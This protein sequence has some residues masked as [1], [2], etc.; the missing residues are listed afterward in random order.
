MFDFSCALG[1]WPHMSSQRQ[2]RGYRGRMRLIAPVA[3][4]LP[5][6]DFFISFLDRTF[7]KGKAL[8]SRLAASVAL[9]AATA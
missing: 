1:V 2:D 4:H 8:A 6:L 3:M 9:E 7:K 5:H